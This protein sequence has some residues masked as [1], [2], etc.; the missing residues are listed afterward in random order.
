MTSRNILDYMASGSP[1]FPLDNHTL[2]PSLC[3]RT[4]TPLPEDRPCPL[5]ATGTRALGIFAATSYHLDG[6]TAWR[7]LEL[8]AGLWFQ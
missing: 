3:S 1:Y 5:D 2:L 8:S 4:G 6:L 7:S